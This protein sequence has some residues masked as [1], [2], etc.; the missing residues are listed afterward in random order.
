[1][2][3]ASKPKKRAINIQLSAAELMPQDEKSLDILHTRAQQLAKQTTETTQ[4][5]TNQYICFTL[6]GMHERYG[7]SYQFIRGIID[8]IV[9]T[10]LP[11]TPNYIA[12]VINRRGNLITIV[13]LKPFFHTQQTQYTEKPY[14]IVSTV[15]DITF[16]ILADSVE[17]SDFYE[18]SSLEPPFAFPDII[19]P[20]LIIGLHRGV[21]AIINVEALILTPELQIKK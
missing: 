7:I 11:C 20:E 13:D 3:S 10:P 14:I 2:E 12:G 19:K 4:T 9:P 15:N 5:S 18:L 21:T 1:M 8:D 16:G 6:G 17:G